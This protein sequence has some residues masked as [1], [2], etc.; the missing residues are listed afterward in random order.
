MAAR[1]PRREPT[2]RADVA[3]TG[4]R[5]TLVLLGVLA[6]AAFT[7]AVLPA[8][9]AGRLIAGQPVTVGAWSGTVWSGTAHALAVRGQ[10][11]GDLRW[12]FRPSALLAAR[13]GA[14]IE[15]AR[16]DGSVAAYASVRDPNV[17]ELED[18]RLDL[19]L[20]AFARG[21]GAGWSGRARG[22]FESVT[23]TQGWP[24]SARGSI[25]LE[26]V[27]MPAPASTAL[28]NLKA[29]FP[30]PRT[31]STG[32]K[33]TARIDG[34]SPLTIDAALVLSAG[35]N[36]EIAGTVA[37]TGP[38]PPGVERALGALGPADAAGRREF[39]AS[40]TF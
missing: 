11:L 17:V 26:G 5:R 38:L 14:S 15:L 10:P 27:A 22:T 13:A 8:S 2:A 19:P 29:T 36:F 32:D 20:A 7:I 6:F 39:S 3:P 9:L 28:G 35:R 34:G 1:K 12:K 23:L 18:V 16:P 30:D 21:P 33:V 31:P 40:G 4:R 24:S 37:G 25:D